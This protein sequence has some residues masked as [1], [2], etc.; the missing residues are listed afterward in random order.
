[1]K[2]N[3]SAVYPTYVTEYDVSNFKILRSYGVNIEG[4]SAICKIRK[5]AVWDSLAHEK[6]LELVT[7]IITNFKLL[8]SINNLYHIGHDVS[9][10]AYKLNIPVIVVE[11]V[12]EML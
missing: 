3:N 10:V 12:I 6:N 8:N 5:D 7:D 1:M 9:M 11:Y 2:K 4:I